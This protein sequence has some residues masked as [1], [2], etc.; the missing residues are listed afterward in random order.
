M[1]LFLTPMRLLEFDNVGPYLTL[2]R[3]AE[4]VSGQG[5][6]SSAYR[7]CSCAV[8]CAKAVA[9]QFTRG[10][11]E[12]YL[13]LSCVPFLAEPMTSS[14]ISSITNQLTVADV[15]ARGV[16]ALPPVIAIPELLHILTTTSY[17][18][19][20]SSIHLTSRARPVFENVSLKMLLGRP[21]AFQ[22]LL[23]CSWARQSA[24][25]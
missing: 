4:P 17:S 25:A 18:V 2:A 21:T 20:S 24:C 6:V 1:T 10:I 5:C 13:Q 8:F 15:M 11:F 12:T 22:P 16:T 23:S 9:D 7:S 14:S 3:A 19:R